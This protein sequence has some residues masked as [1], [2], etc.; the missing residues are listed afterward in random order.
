MS[1]YLLNV[2]EERFNPFQIF[3]QT[4]DDTVVKTNTKVKFSG[5]LKRGGN[6]VGDVIRPSNG[7]WTADWFF[8]VIKKKVDTHSLD[9]ERFKNYC[10]RRIMKSLDSTDVREV[11]YM[12]K[13]I[14]RNK[15]YSKDMA[16]VRTVIQN[17]K[18]SY[19]PIGMFE[20]SMLRDY[21]KINIVAR[22]VGA[23]QEIFEA[24]SD[25]TIVFVVEDGGAYPV[26]L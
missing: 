8:N 16:S 14:R 24:D 20:L 25:K 5:E 6:V 11:K 4:Y 17:F 1:D 15:L 26:N 7:K 13:E 21:L 22:K 9:S 19:G 2:Y 10:K 3:R 18:K 12:T 23:E